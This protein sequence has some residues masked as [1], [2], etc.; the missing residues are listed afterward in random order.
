MSRRMQISSGAC[1][2][3]L[4]IASTLA[5]GVAFAAA[6]PTGTYGVKDAPFT[7]SFDDKGKFH[8]NKGETLEVTGSYAVKGGELRL[9][10]SSGPWACTKDGEQ[11]GTYS[12]KYQ[13]GVLTFHKVADMCED[14][15]KSL[16]NLGWKRQA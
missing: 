6:F 12:W 2:W 9:T 4:G 8:V 5:L 7:V 15:V 10:D 3:A 1:A 11:T 13:D 14:R 16:V